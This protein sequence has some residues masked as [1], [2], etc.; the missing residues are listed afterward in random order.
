M[1]L[2]VGAQASRHQL[3]MHRHVC[4]DMWK[5]MC[6]TICI[7]MHGDMSAD[8]FIDMHTDMHIGV[9]LCI[10]TTVDMFTG[11]PIHMCGHVQ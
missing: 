9:D 11:M 1:G 7:G 8:M 5:D 6:I 2:S 4:L 10:R 3:G